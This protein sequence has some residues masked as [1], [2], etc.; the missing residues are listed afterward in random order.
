MFMV[1]IGC[2]MKQNIPSTLALSILALGLLKAPAAQAAVSAQTLANLNAAFQGESNAAGRYAKFAEKAVAEG[3]P[4]VGRL[5]RAAAASESIHRDTHRKTILE[6]GGTVATFQLDPVQPGTTAENLK[7][8]VAGE[9]HERDTMYPEFLALAK[10]DDSRPAIRTL[11][12]ALES[13][14]A[15]A[16]LYQE[17]LDNLGKNPAADYYVCAV[18]GETLTVLPAKR[19]PVCRK[20]KDEFTRIN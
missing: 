12:F 9:S 1:H 4:Q 8:A 14:K 16:R 2:T 5:F 11:T 15:H 19:C 10:T 13:E 3:F 7:A 18:C 17:A 20:G 6:L